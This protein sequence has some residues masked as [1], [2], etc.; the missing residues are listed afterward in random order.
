MNTVD[1]SVKKNQNV[2]LLTFLNSMYYT[3]PIGMFLTAC[4]FLF[5]SVRNYYFDWMIVVL[6]T[7][8]VCM[9]VNFYKMFVLYQQSGLFEKSES[10]FTTTQ[11]SYSISNA[12]LATS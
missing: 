3:F 5:E 12:N 1:A 4:N 10:T 6:P 2:F 8:A 11:V 9:I 7:V